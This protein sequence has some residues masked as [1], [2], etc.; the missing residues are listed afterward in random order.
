MK[1]V[2]RVIFLLAVVLG[3][4]VSAGAEY[5]NEG[6]SGTASD[7]YVIDTNA[8]LVALRD[9]VNDGIEEADKYYKLTQ[10]LNI[11]QYTDWESI[12][13]DSH[14]FTGHFDGNEK[15]IHVNISRGN[16]NGG[17][18]GHVKTDDNTYSVQK[19]TVSGTVQSSSGGGL[20][21]NIYSGIIDGCT[22]TGTLE[23][24]GS[25]YEGSI[26]GI[27]ANMEGG[28]ITNCNV[29]ATISG[30]D[31]NKNVSY[32]G[33]IVGYMTGGS[34]ENCEVNGTTLSV[35]NCAGGIAGY[36]KIATF[37]AINNCVFSGTVETSRKRG[38]KHAGGIVGYIEG[39]TLKNNHVTAEANS[40][41]EISSVNGDLNYAGGIAGRIGESTVLEDCDVASIVTVSGGEDAE[42]I[43]GIV[44][45]MNAS[46]LRN[47]QSYASIEGDV[48][49][50]G[51]VVGKL[52]AA[53]YTISNNKYS[54]AEHGIGNNAQG[55]P[56]EEGC[57]KVG[58]SISITTSSLP[59]AVAEEAYSVTLETNS[60]SAVVWSL[61]N[62]TSLPEGLTLD[63]TSGTISGTP[64]TKGDY[65]FTVKASPASG[66]PATKEFTLAVQEKGSDVTLSITTSSLPAGTAGQSYSASLTSNPSGANWTLASGNLPNGL[67]LSSSG[68][69]SGTPIASGASTF[70]VRATYSGVSATRQLSITINSGSSP[71]TIVI[72]TTSLPN[73]TAGQ[74]YS[75]SL[76]SNPSGATWAVAS[77]SLPNGLSLSSNG[78]ISGTPTSAGTAT[79]TVRATYGTASATQ[80][81]TITINAASLTITTNSLPSGQVG[82]SYSA[83][84]SASASGVTWSVYSG[85]LP[86]GLTLVE[87]RG[88]ISGTPTSAGTFS[89][90]IQARNNYASTTKS[91]SIRI[92]GSNNNSDDSDSGGGGC[93]SGLGIMSMMLLGVMAFRKSHK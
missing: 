74:T 15:S 90:S 3:L 24:T 22:F 54:S 71:A 35:F 37:E 83:N 6:H 28:K 89:F 51:G 48:P 70:T 77:G 39:G 92:S 64:K 87:S 58:A 47:N 44:G 79:F 43:G 33:G 13:T 21:E 10:N 30:G 31:D 25:W 73:G 59:N 78:T 20:A 19:L 88:V 16:H 17:V 63:R 66:A 7:P 65:T 8:D 14:P 60:S 49:N 91:F 86:N 2:L 26:G 53:S 46:T 45:I 42:G 69:I 62:G 23:K 55:V 9:R 4:A 5:Y 29:T 93:D 85:S 12:G 81:L 52:D 76:A 32:G 34:I 67:T 75:A 41:S 50:M 68:T 11:S 57:I 36:A 38:T 84:L 1:K 72:T 82:G 56:S 18:F 61:T 80:N 27:A 40:Q